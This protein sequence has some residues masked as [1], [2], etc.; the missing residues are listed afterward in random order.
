[1]NRLLKY[2]SCTAFSAA[3]IACAAFTAVSADEKETTA[4]VVT[5]AA[6]TT[7]ETTAF[8]IAT[9]TTATTV[10]STSITTTAAKTTEAPEISQTTATTAD[11]EETTTV[12]TKR[13]SS[14]PP[15]I[16]EDIKEGWNDIDGKWYYFNGEKFLT[17]VQKIDK[18]Y[19]LFAYNGSLKTGWQTVKEKRRFYDSE[20][21]SPVYG[22]IDYLGNT[23]FND[24]E[25]G[26]VT[27]MQKIGEKT[28]IFTK[29]GA[30][31][32]GFVKY[33]GYIYF[34]EEDGAIYYGDEKKTPVR[35]GD[36][37]Y[38]VNAKGQVACGWQTVNGLRKYYDYETGQCIYGW[39]TDCYGGSF[40]V[41]AKNGKYT[42]EKIID[43]HKYR[44]TDKGRLCTGM[45][46]FTLSDNTTEVY[47]FYPDGTY[48]ANCFLKTE[49]GT[50]HFEDDGIMSTGWRGVEDDIYYFAEDGK[51]T[52]GFFT[53]SNKTYYFDKDGK[54]QTGLVTADKDKYLFN[55]DGVMQYGFQMVGKDTYYFD[56]TTGKAYRGW[57]E[58]NS[59]KR[60]FLD[61]GVMA[62]GFCKIKDDTYYFDKDG[63]ITIGWMELSGAKYYFDESGKM[64][65][66]RHE[67]G[68]K[69]YLF[70]SDGKMADTGNQ[71]IVVKALSQ[72]GQE[73]GKPYW[74]W[75]G[76]S[77][78]FEWCA[79]F[80]SWCANQCGYT[81]KQNCIEFISCR[82]G[83]NWFKDHSQ[84]KGKNYI[85]KSGD[86]IFFDWEP[87]GVADHVGI[88]D[89]Y[90]DGYVYTVEGNSDDKVRKKSYSI[91]SENIFGFAAPNF[92]QE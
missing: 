43:G 24:K 19:Y 13:V 57:Q 64:Y 68:G 90:E 32:A 40:Y 52:V 84:W 46:E 18:E 80:V 81:A 23:Y 59:K 16:P 48:A 20:T 87:D 33:N 5:E 50:Y 30:L 10:T 1:M 79:C 26:K 12:T 49:E 60:Y 83:I 4:P 44:F 27:G 77:Y 58:I 34:C 29:Y 45:Q 72:L 71:T 85:P 55:I 6:V 8:E 42:G 74:T 82:V 62:T 17:G 28:Y 76:S 14:T 38:I 39:I 61:S 9:K 66:Y 86:F 63:V 22:W 88:V 92:P 89:Y 65:T 41:D 53:Q 47:Y 78:R 67:I 36:E 54:L 7:A 15:D 91:K 11:A 25:T 69:N 75:W 2:L 51:M 73:G 3:A 37:Y 56:L 70:Y 31:Q 35:F 21:H